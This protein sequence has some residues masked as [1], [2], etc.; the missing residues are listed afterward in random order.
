LGQLSTK[1]FFWKMIEK[2]QVIIREATI[3]DAPRVSNMLMNL[4]LDQPGA[5]DVEKSREHW[6]RLWTNNPYY[7]IF[8]EPFLYGWVLEFNSDV[9]GFFGS[10]PRVYYFDGKPFAACIGSQWGVKKEFRSFTSMLSDKFFL[11]NPISLKL[12][13]TAIKPAGKLFEKYGG[14]KMPLPEMQ[15]VSMI[16]INLGNLISYKY[17][18]LLSKVSFIKPFFKILNLWNLQFRLLPENKNFK[19]IDVNNLPKELDLFID[20]VVKREKGLVAS[21]QLDVLKW[22]YTGGNENFKKTIFLYY[23]HQKVAGYASLIDEPIKEKEK[24]KRY[25]IVDL[26]AENKEIKR[27]MIKEL[28]RYS[29]KNKVDILE[30]QYPGLIDKSEVPAIILSRKLPQFSLYYQTT[31]EVLDTLLQD[32]K[33]WHIMPF[34]GDTC[35]G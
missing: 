5:E 16:P 24:L 1:I 12:A 7:K 23:N 34:D 26:I 15:T 32:K 35:L 20:S 18:N 11:E 30:L 14:K 28:I 22:Y 17:E 3:E 21:R 13:T 10:I 2:D 31:D 33:N 8:N 4:G 27:S 29:Y 19:K 6:D 9:V 25:K